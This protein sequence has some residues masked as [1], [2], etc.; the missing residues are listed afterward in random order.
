MT[1]APQSTDPATL[2]VARMARVLAEAK[3]RDPMAWS[4][5]LVHGYAAR[6][7]GSIIIAAAIIDLDNSEI[8]EYL[9]ADMRND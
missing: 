7:G 5:P 8:A 6:R 9:L 4:I 3:R 2:R 1:D